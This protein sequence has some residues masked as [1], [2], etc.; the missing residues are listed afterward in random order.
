MSIPCKHPDGCTKPSRINGWCKAH[1]SRI[2]RT[3]TSGCA[4]VPAPKKDC[5]A[6][7]CDRTVDRSGGLGYCGKHYQRIR[8]HG[9]ASITAVGGA[10]LPG[11]LN[12]HWSECPTY[13]AVHLR[14]KSVLGSASRHL[15]VDCGRTAREWSYDHCAP[16]EQIAKDGPFSKLASH[17]WPRC[18]QC[19]RVM[20]R[21]INGNRDHMEDQ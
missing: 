15:C 7:G 20:D 11:S 19:H 14:L 3:G 1:Y 13:N 12:P 5:T 4:E 9:D 16:D 8:K 10:S 2:A 21:A 17:Y 6:D 18:T